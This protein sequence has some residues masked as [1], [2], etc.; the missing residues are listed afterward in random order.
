M[1]CAICNQRLLKFETG[2]VRKETRDICT[3][4]RSLVGPALH[5]CNGCFNLRMESG[6]R[7][8]R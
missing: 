8:V 7:K 3:G 5:V 1:R 6:H 2:K 4:K